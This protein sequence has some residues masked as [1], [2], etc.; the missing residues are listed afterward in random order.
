MG[1]VPEKPKHLPTPEE[2]SW[3]LMAHLSSLLAMALVGMMVFLV[4]W[5]FG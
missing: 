3:G 4:P 5:S 1:P 2:Y